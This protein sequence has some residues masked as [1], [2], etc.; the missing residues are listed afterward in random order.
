MFCFLSCCC[1]CCV[2]D[3]K[4]IKPEDS[5]KKCAS[6][7]DYLNVISTATPVSPYVPNTTDKIRDSL[8]ESYDFERL[9]S[10]ATLEYANNN[11]GN[12]FHKLAFEFSDEKL[13]RR[14]QINMVLGLIDDQL[15]RGVDISKRD[16]LGHTPV[17]AAL[18]YQHGFFAI[19]LHQVVAKPP[20]SKI[21]Q[22]E[23]DRLMKTHEAQGFLDR[24]T[25]KL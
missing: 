11:D 13:T 12:N 21:F 14:D 8:K 23:Y 10:P 22:R 19:C 20:Y 7:L 1:C 2:D 24:L 15:K 4:P 17:E 6:D 18:S 5:K 9:F 25:L 16:I 3:V